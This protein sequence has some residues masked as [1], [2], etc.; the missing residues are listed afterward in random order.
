MTLLG[1]P[2]QSGD[3]HGKQLDD[4]G[5]VDIGL[6]AQGEQGS[7]REGRA[8]H[9]IHQ[10]QNGTALGCEIGLQLSTIDIGDRNGG[11]QTE[12]EQREDGKEDLVA[13][14]TFL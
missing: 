7:H 4:N 8:A 12:D 11:A 6:H 9:G 14:L 2:L 10:P 1:Q 3:G 13:Q 5:A